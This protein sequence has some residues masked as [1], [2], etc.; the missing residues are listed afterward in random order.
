[1]GV[2]GRL[3]R[4]LGKVDEAT[5]EVELAALEQVHRAEGAV[6]EATGGRLFDAL[7]KADEEAEA[8]HARLHPGEHEQVEEEEPREGS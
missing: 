5:A 8:L 2:I 6:D 3:R 7:E 4:W 1:V